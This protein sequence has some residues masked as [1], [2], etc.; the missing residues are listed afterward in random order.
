MHDVKIFERERV[1]HG[2]TPRSGRVTEVDAVAGFHRFVVEGDDFE[3]MASL[4]PTDHFKIVMDESCG[5][6]D[7]RQKPDGGLDVPAGCVKR[8]LTPRWL[9]GSRLVFDIVEHPEGPLMDWVRAARC[10]TKITTIGPRGSK[11]IPNSPRL[12]LGSDSSA[13]PALARWLETASAEHIDIVINCPDVD[14]LEYLAD[15]IH[16]EN[17]QVHDVS[18]DPGRTVELLKTIN[19]TCDTY[20]WFGGEATWLIEPRRWLRNESRIDKKN[21]DMTGYWKRGVQG[22]DH[23]APIDPREEVATA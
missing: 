4:S 20:A 15:L 10:G 5:A 2:L 12:L 6:A 14:A 9:D 19:P 11:L 1:M 13:L 16:G 18:T 7:V 8:D 23:H 3:T 17:V 22:H 21:I